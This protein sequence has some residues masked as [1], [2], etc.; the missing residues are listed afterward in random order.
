MLGQASLA[1]GNG[2][3]TDAIVPFS[4]SAETLGT[5]GKMVHFL[6]QDDLGY[7]DCDFDL[8]IVFKASTFQTTD[9]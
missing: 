4:C 1:V 8:G 6:N 7:Y 2:V 3:L 9:Y 5:M